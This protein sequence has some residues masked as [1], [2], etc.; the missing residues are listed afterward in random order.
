MVR[1]YQMGGG[2]LVFRLGGDPEGGWLVDW[3]FVN[4][5]WCVLYVRMVVRI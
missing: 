4:M 1:G 3:K 2:G 5:W